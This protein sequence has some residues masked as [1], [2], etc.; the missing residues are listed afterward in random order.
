MLKYNID[1]E[2]MGM[3]VTIVIA[4][5]FRM[6]Y[7]SR[8]RS[9]MAF[10]KLV[11]W[12]LAAQALD[13]ITAITFSFEDPRY[14]LFNL[15]MTTGYFLC[16]F[17]TSVCFERY[18]V[19]YIPERKFNKIYEIIRKGM[20]V[21]YLIQ[22]A[23]NP[24]TK[25]S[26]YFTD[27]GIYLHGPIYY[28]GY[29]MPGIFALISLYHIVRYRRFFSKKQ[30]IASVS[31]HF[32]VFGAM[33]LQATVF[34]DIYLTYGLIPISLL[35]IMF[36]LET[37]DYRK[38]LS[39]MEELEAAKQEAWRANRVKS[40]FLA[41]MSHEIRTP[42]N[43]V[44][45]FDE[46]IL[47]ESKEKEVIAYAA[48]IKS[49]GQNLLGLVN[50]ILDLSK[51]EA[52]KME[53]IEAEYEPVTG[54]S[55]LIK[56]ISPRAAEKGLTLSC[57]I[58]EDIPRRLIGDDVRIIQV[59]T[60]LLTNAVKYTQKGEVSLSVSVSKEEEDSVTLLYEV[61]D[62]G[63]GIKDE[64]KEKLF[65]EFSR[66]EGEATHRIEG[67]GLG[68]P[69]T[70][71]CLKLMGSRLEVDSIYGTGSTF[72]FQLKQKVADRTPIGDFEK[73]RISDAIDV[74]VFHEDFTAPDAKVLVVDD[75][76]LNLK[77]F[78]GLLKKSKMDIVTAGSG[79]EAIKMIRKNRYDVIF[80]DHQ[81][82]DMDGIETLEA[83]KEDKEAQID[84]VPVI[85]LTANA[86]AGARDMYMQKGFSD[87]LTK[88]IDGW[89]LLK[90][91]HKWLP[92]EKIKAMEDEEEKKDTKRVISEEP[93]EDDDSDVMEFLPV[94]ESGTAA[95]SDNSWLGRM[96]AL[97]I[98]TK[99]GLLYAGSSED[100]Y[101]EILGDFA[102]DFA[103]KSGEINECFDNKD[104]ENYGVHVHALKSTAKMIGAMDLSKEAK[105]LEFAAKD[106]DV[107]LIEAD[108][109]DLMEHYAKL[110][111]AVS[112]AL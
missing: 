73:A 105:K 25:L 23:T 58:D 46:M 109:S 61:S 63:I 30:W 57:D 39:T 96:K 60:N 72:H 29:I 110:C 32:V 90:M 1:Y 44:L 59:L 106:G 84:K 81:M 91:L 37:P 86:I 102:K 104:W 112:K 12:I 52:G 101:K 14:N 53:I 38:L 74:E 18:I 108:H 26:F 62:T 5:A 97:D 83:L 67:T 78:K 98:D 103:D 15:I 31:F 71:K 36:S 41:N 77:V 88:P 27:E 69:I 42:I 89:E 35:V 56:M 75:V 19:S 21:V 85:A 33:I 17:A 9:D 10:M 70:M 16:A 43:A 100:F 47:R 28:I 22:A 80:M 76:E 51:I 87:Y 99:A 40:D 68:L 4:I 24:F 107:M 92:A 34:P 55:E 93:E 54:L 7:V 82:P 48:N 20:I 111:A 49:S 45:G 79:A 11:H 95:D 65:S 3:L 6:N 13:M 64:D 94:G 50:D 2:I 8:T 66:V